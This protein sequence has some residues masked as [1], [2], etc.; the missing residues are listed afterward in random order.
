[1]V[2]VLVNTV[3][4]EGTSRPM[5]RESQECGNGPFLPSIQGYLRLA[6]LIWHAR[7]SWLDG[8]FSVMDCDAAIA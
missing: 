7:L 4:I 8:I 2:D 6:P 3:L 5:P 1:M